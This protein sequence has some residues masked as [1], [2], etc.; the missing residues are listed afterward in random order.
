MKHHLQN[1]LKS[2]LK[3]AILLKNSARTLLAHKTFLS[4]QFIFYLPLRLKSKN[5]LQHME[6]F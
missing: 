5:A 2:G 6:L 1:Y 4:C 3:D